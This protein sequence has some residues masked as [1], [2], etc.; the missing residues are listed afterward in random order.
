MVR[1]L[2]SRLGWVPGRGNYLNYA[3]EQEEL[4]LRGA[5]AQPFEPPPAIYGG[6]RRAFRGN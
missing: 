4:K 5:G 2:F 3:I 6:P 1:R